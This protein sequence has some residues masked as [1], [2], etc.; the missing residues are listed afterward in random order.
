MRE[1]INV[2]SEI[3]FQPSTLKLT[4]AYYAKY[5]SISKILDENPAILD[6]VH[7]ELKKPLK[8]ATVKGKDGREHRITSDQVLRVVL[9]QIIE[10]ASLREIV[11][12]ID[13]SNFLRRFARI[14]NGPMMDFTTLDKLKNSIPPT[15]WKK[16]NRLLAQHAVQKKLID[17]EK[18]VLGVRSSL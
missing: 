15:T 5:E 17:G 8:Y 12:R 18:V 9:C 1:K 10:G 4:N 7:G 6:E 16:V 11:I 13:D 3:D 2:Q 14:Y